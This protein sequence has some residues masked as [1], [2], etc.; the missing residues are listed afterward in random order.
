MKIEITSKT[1][2]PNFYRISKSEK[3][4]FVSQGVVFNNNIDIKIGTKIDM[5]DHFKRND[6]GFYQ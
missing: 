1:K 4:G 6:R 3:N 5:P 2:N